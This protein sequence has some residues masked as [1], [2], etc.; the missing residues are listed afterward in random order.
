[1]FIGYWHKGNKNNYQDN[2]SDIEES[3]GGYITGIK[4]ALMQIHRPVYIVEHNG[5]T[6]GASGGVASIAHLNR[7]SDKNPPFADIE[8]DAG[9]YYDTETRGDSFKILAYA[10]PL[11]L[12][13]LGDASF[14]A[15]HNLKYPYI[16]G[17]MAN[18]ITSVEIV[19]SMA[20]NGMMA[21]FGSGGLSLSDV[22]GAIITLKKNLGPYS[23]SADSAIS[24]SS[25]AWG[26]NFIH[27]HGD[28]ELEMALASLYIRHGVHRISAAAFMRITIALVYY[29]LQGIHRNMEGKIITPN[30]IIAK[31]SRVEVARQFF[32]P[33][34]KKLV[35]EL[36]NQGLISEDEAELSQYIPMAQDLTAEADSGGHTDNRP[37]I[38]LWPTMIALKDQFNK[39]FN[40]QEPLCVGFAGGIATPEST[41]A[42]F[43]MGAAYVLTGSINQSCLEAGTSDGVKL[44]LAQAEQADVAMA[45]AADMFEIG[46]RVQV[47][48]RGTMFSVRAEKLY[49]I[50][51]N[52]ERFEDVPEKLRREV[53]ERYLQADFNQKWEETKAF[54]QT[55]NIREIERAEGDSRY[56]MALV[57]RS[58]L[59]LSSRWSIAGDQKRVM[60]YQIWC[61]PAI[62]AFNQWV[63]GTFMEKSENRKVADIAINLLFGASVCTR[64][65]WLKSQGGDPI[66]AGAGSF[67]PLKISELITYISEEVN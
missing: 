6:T 31:V 35:D 1:M 22:E 59:G 20:K 45:P 63:K 32:S 66:P 11:P 23:Y 46:A 41:A 57:F 52:Y 17:A 37:A 8:T 36:M 49:Q 58:Y 40:Y 19:E 62:G 4:D 47:L 64:A 51:K 3:A 56:K 10:P 21:F 29:R 16:A 5:E 2:G 53:E 44:L 42:A 18:G 34:P 27:S 39:E 14:K 65:G 28:P 55:R 54:F 60:D 50:Y 15:R 43:Q 13:H 30:Q 9:Y 48:K 61:G 38:A 26:F 33:P 25:T 67:K 7:N 12:E 24:P